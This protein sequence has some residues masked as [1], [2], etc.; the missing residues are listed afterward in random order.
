MMRNKASK[1]QHVCRV[2]AACSS[3]TGGEEQE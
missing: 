3:Q 2:M 1:S